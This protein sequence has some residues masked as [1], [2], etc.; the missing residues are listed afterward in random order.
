MVAVSDILPVKRAESPATMPPGRAGFA[1]G[2]NINPGCDDDGWIVPPPVCLSDGTQLQLYKDGESLRAAYQAIEQARRR[3]CVEMYIFADDVTGHA[4]ADLLAQRARDG[5]RVY[6]IYDSFGSRGLMGG[7][8]EPLRKMKAAGVRLEQFHP[9]RPWECQFSWHPFNRDHRKMFI[10]DDDIAGIG[11]LNIGNEYAGSW[12]VS[13]VTGDFWRDNAMGIRGP[14]AAPFHRA[15]RRSWHY[16]KRGGRMRRLAHAEHVDDPNTELAILA[17]SPTM[18]SELRPTI[19]RL[20][21]SAQCSITLTMAYFAP[22]DALVRELCFAASRR[23][24]RVRI[25]L[26]GVSDVPMVRLAGRAFYDDLLNAGVEVYERQHAVLHAKTL[27]IDGQTTVIG[28]GNLDYRSIEYNCELSAIVR[29]PTFG[30]QIELLFENDIRYA[31]QIKEEEWHRLPGWDRF[32]QWAVSR[33]RYV[34]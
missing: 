18:D 28:S 14:G 27:C 9:M 13:D 5:V 24:V 26:P 12:I 4:F 7:L 17:S 6:V 32:V 21:R 11:G 33:A 20:L 15:F 30:E 25:M 10:V 16:V 34:L 1:A 19:A 8:T 22:D 29:S 2:I 31:K 23:K 3:V